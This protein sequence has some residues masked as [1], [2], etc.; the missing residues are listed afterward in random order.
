M[1]EMKVSF[2]GPLRID[3]YGDYTKK[4]LVTISE[5]MDNKINRISDKIVNGNSFFVL[6]R[7]W[8]TDYI[9]K[10]Y[11]WEN[12]IKLVDT[13]EYD[14]RGKN[15]QVNIDTYDLT[16]GIAWFR[17]VKRYKDYT[18]CKLYISVKDDAILAVIKHHE[19]STIFDDIIP[20]G[21]TV[22]NCYAS[23]DIGK[24]DMKENGVD[25]FGYFHV[26]DG[27]IRDGIRLYDSFKN[28]RDWKNLPT[29]KIASDILVLEYE[30]YKKND[31]NIY[32]M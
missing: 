17:Q 19:N 7:E 15:V 29:E 30:P 4:F 21:E 5:K 2:V 20:W 27:R 9:I 16:A 24:Y 18:N 1:N 22:E 3:V 26:F 6:Y 11:E 10:L 32:T 8:K 14:D 23:Y 12:G 13:I 25:K 28:P 31:I